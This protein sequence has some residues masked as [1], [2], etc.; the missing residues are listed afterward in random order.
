MPIPEEREIESPHIEE[1]QAKQSN[2]EKSLKEKKPN[3]WGIWVDVNRE[4]GRTPPFTT[5]KDTRAAKSILAQIKDPEKYTDILR[6]FLA[7]DDKFLMQNG[8]SISFL[9]SK[10]NKY[11]NQCYKPKISDSYS[12][13]DDQIAEIYANEEKFAADE[14]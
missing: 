13:S 10:I 6:Q 11:L 12:L 3:A 2:T 9:T 8:H 5:G 7:D 4:F 14:S 1:L